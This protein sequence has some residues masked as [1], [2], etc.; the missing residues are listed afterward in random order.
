MQRFTPDRSYSGGRWTIRAAYT[1]AGATRATHAVRL[2]RLTPDEVETFDP[3][4]IMGL[5]YN[6][7][8][9]V[10][11]L[12]PRDVDVNYLIAYRKPA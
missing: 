5:T 3:I 10:Y 2:D 11:A 12:N 8:T 1:P 9:R 6:P 4:E 7:I